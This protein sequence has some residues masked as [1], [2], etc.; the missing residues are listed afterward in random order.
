MIPRFYLA[1]PL[2][3]D[4]QERLVKENMFSFIFGNAMFICTFSF[5]ATIPVKTG[6]G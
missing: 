4:R 1:M 5:I 3:F 2:I 6:Y